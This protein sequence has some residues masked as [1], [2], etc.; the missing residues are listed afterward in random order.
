M[1]RKRDFYEIDFSYLVIIKK[2]I[3]VKIWNFH[4]ILVIFFDKLEKILKF[5]NPWAIYIIII[6]IY[7]IIKYSTSSF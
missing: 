2:S 1:Y 7:Y 6:I 5:D 3:M 4:Q